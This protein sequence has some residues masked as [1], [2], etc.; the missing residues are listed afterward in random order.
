MIR[1]FEAADL[2]AVMDLWLAANLDAHDFIPA[3]YW[4]RHVPTV[5]KM[6][7]E[8]EV[9]VS[10][11]DG[12]I[13]G[14]LGLSGDYIAGIFVKKSARRAGVGTELLH[15]AKKRRE[16]LHLSVYQKNTPAVRFYEREGFYVTSQGPDEDTGEEALELSWVP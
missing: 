6:I 8:A 11:Q 12:I 4:Q 13:L 2:D 7:P 10:E 14:F 9:Y 3:D 15:A 1:T 5:R 16:K